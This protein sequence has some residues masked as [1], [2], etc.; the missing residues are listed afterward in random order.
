MGEAGAAADGDGRFKVIIVGAGVSG[1]IL[2]HALHRADIDYVVLD[3]HPV[4]P[5]WGISISMY[6]NGMRI[7]DQLGLYDVLDTKRAEM[8]D[9]H[10]RG[11]D[12][13][14]YD[15]YP[16]LKEC[17]DSGGYV[18]ITMERRVF[19]QTIYDELPD[20]SKVIEGARVSDIVEDE[21]RVQVVLANGTVHEGDIVV[22][23]DGVHSAVRELMWA[24]AHRLSPG[25]VTVAEKQRMTASYVCLI[26]IAPYQEGVGAV[27]VSSVSYAGFS[28]LFLTQPDAIYFLVHIKRPGNKTAKYPNRLR[29]TDADVEAEASKYLDCPVSETLVFGDLW[30]T[31]TRGQLVALEEGVLSRWT[32][33]CGD[34]AHK[35]TPNAGFGGN[36]AIEGAVALANE[37]YAVVHH[38][39]PDA[40]QNQTKKP[41]DEEIRHA[42]QKYQEGHMARAKMFYYMSW[43]WT[44][45]QAYDGWGWY[46]AQRWALPYLWGVGTRRICELMTYAPKLSYVPF[47]ERSGTL[48]WKKHEWELPEETAKSQTSSSGRSVISRFTSIIIIS[49]LIYAASV[50][51]RGEQ[52]NCSLDLEIGN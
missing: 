20:K 46:V 14:T 8:Y 44:R 26:G 27:S 22:G 33:L 31:R 41:S 15:T 29:F 36:L 34:S 10:L 19:L 7:L 23:C 3:K 40:K 18:A 50:W 37:I 2:A 49:A 47:N 21:S 35:V 38:R 12:G 17:S 52:P 11:S 32:V 42:F 16:F 4:A 39:R 1:L 28:F 45:M 51:Y 6:P 25:L 43:A 9:F 24:R 13:N 48:G 5:A 30:R